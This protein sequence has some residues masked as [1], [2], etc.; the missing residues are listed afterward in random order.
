MNLVTDVIYYIT[1][2]AMIFSLPGLIICVL[3]FLIKPHL[4]NNRK[5]IKNSYSR[6][7]I[8]MI[9]LTSFFVAVI[10]FGTVLAAT[11]PASVKQARIEQEAATAKAELTKKQQEEQAAADQAKQR[12]LDAAKPV[13]KTETKTEAVPFEST[14]QNDNT[15][16]SGTN[17]VSVTG[18]NGERTITDEV[19]YVKNVETARKEVKNE[20]TKA[21][22]TQVTLVG[23]YIAPVVQ[24]PAPVYVAPQ[25]SVRIG[26]TCND[27]SH[28]T[29]TGSGACS[30]HGGVAVWLY[31]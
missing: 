6:K 19:T 7:K 4:L 25:P 23:T 11:E 24:A 17:R 2:V 18:V 12:E 29:A 14:N 9:G 1:S 26:A 28:S 5:I 20:I 16:A 21:P 3:L 13:V 31:S 8:A 10:G 22:V 15:I 27:G 30:H